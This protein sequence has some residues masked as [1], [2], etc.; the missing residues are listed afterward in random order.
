MEILNQ[1]QEKHAD[2]L[3]DSSHI[4]MM[5]VAFGVCTFFFSKPNLQTQSIW[6][7]TIDQTA[8]VIK[9]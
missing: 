5:S 3:C 4:S 2:M 6:F 7:I 8:S 1:L 9:D